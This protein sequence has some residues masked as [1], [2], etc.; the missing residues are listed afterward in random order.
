MHALYKVRV[1]ADFVLILSPNPTVIIPD[2]FIVQQ[3]NCSGFLFAVFEI[4]RN[5]DIKTCKLQDCGTCAVV[6]LFK[7][8]PIKGNLSYELS[9]QI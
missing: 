9:G 3:I 7:T 4:R 6:P 5:H 8:T 2:G 1:I